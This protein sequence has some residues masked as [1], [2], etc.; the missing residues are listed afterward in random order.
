MRNV[1]PFHYSVSNQYQAMG[2]PITV[3]VINVREGAV[4]SP[5]TITVTASEG[6]STTSYSV[7]TFQAIDQDTGRPATNVR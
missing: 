7:G 6:T 1:A 4:F 5:S 3:Q 2:T